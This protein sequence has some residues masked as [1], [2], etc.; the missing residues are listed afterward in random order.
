MG[1]DAVSSL[2]L[3]SDVAAL[4]GSHKLH[5][6]LYPSHFTLN[7]NDETV[8]R[9]PLNSRMFQQRTQGDHDELSL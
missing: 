7:C 3:N 1:L 5:V 6:S 4:Q 2:E 8:E 9:L